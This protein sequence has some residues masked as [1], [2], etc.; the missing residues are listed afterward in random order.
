MSWSRRLAVGAGAL[1]LVAGVMPGYAGAPHTGVVSANPVDWTPDVEDGKVNAT[2]TVD[3]VTVAVGKFTTVRERGAAG[4]MTRNNI[5]AFDSR[6]EVSDTFTPDVGTSEVFDVVPAGDGRSVYIGGVFRSVNG[7]RRTARVARVDIDTGQVLRSFKSPNFNRKVN[8]LH[9]ANGR[10]YVGGWFTR[11]GGQPH[12]ALVALDPAT[13]GKTGHLNLT[14]SETWNGGRLGIDEF[15]MTSDGSKL[16]AIGNFRKVEGQVRNQIVM[17]DTAGDVAQL[18]SWATSRYGTKCSSRFDT[19]MWGVDF[20]PD[21]SYFVV[22]TTGAFSG[23]VGSGTL[24]DTAARWETHRSG[25]GQQPTWVDY[26]GGDTLTEVEV[27]DHAVYIGGHFRWANS[28]YVADRVGPGAVRRMG[29]AALDVR[30]GLPLRWNPGRAR[31]WGVWGFEST[32]DGLWVGHDTDRL[33]REHRAGVALLPMQGGATLPPDNTGSLPGD[34]YL[35]ARGGL[36]NDVEM[37]TMSASGVS[38]TSDVDPGGIDWSRV[39]GAFM[40]DGRLYTGWS[41]GTFTWRPYNGRVF[42]TPRVIDLNGLTAFASELTTIRAMWFDRETGRLYFTL[43]GVN[44]LFYR[45]FTP[46][47]RTVGAVRFTAPSTPGVD[48]RAV[49]DGFLAGGRLYAATTDGSLRSL[50]WDRGVAGTARVESGPASDGTS[51]NAR[52]LFLFAS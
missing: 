50:P 46:E 36:G 10:L 39:R 17:V 34:V 33:G 13:G 19:Y 32:A 42:G 11:V 48:W 18:S 21:G 40:V 49:T 2:A 52:G 31:G 5:F 24:C 28:P 27:T 37:H 8:S 25:P 51:W 14:F 38:A 43:N 41:N 30:N 44:A 29:L 6:G 7:E 3:G 20:A 26:M 23:G 1:A 45:Y 9:L 4:T 22:G 15:T 16:V 12:T 47:S 35:L